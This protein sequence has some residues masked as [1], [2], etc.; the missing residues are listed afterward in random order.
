[1]CWQGHQRA[2]LV[3]LHIPLEFPGGSELKPESNTC[4]GGYQTVSPIFARDFNKRRR[5]RELT[6]EQ[7]QEIKESFE[8]F[9]TDKDGA[10]DYH[11]LKVSAL[12][13]L[14]DSSKEYGHKFS[15]AFAVHWFLCRL[16]FVMSCF[17]SP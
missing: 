15:T 2:N 6:E 4:S 9:D 13:R 8:L 17:R 16:S 12:L 1:M 7:K 14:T 5:R 11:E 3:Q 10:I